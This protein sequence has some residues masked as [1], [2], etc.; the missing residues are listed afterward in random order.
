MQKYSVEQPT[1][2]NDKTNQMFTE[3]QGETSCAM[4]RYEVGLLL[5]T[6]FVTEFFMYILK[7]SLNLTC[8]LSYVWLDGLNKT[9]TVSTWEGVGTCVGALHGCCRS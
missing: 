7:C 3:K 4:E 6:Y 5:I 1:N 9:V 8:P 2:M